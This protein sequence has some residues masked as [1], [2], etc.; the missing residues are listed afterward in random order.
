MVEQDMGKWL[1]ATALVGVV[2]AGWLWQRRRQ[3]LSG[4]VVL[5][6]G[7]SRGLG[8][9][10]AQEFARQGCRLAI[11][12]R[13]EAELERARYRLSLAGAEVI[14][15]LCDIGDQR[16]VERWV[17]LSL[18]RFGQIDILVNNA[19]IIQVGPLETMTRQD[20][21]KALDVMFWGG[22]H[23]TLAVLPPMQQQGAGQIVNITSIGGKVSVP[24]LLPYNCAKAAF[25]SLSEGLRAELQPHGI[26]VLT[27]VPGL[28]RTGSHLNAF[29]NGQQANEFTWFSLGASLPL[30]SM[31]AERAA[32][33]IVAATKKRETE[34][35]LTIPANL[36]A[37]FHGVFPGLTTEIIS[38][39]AR[40]LL[41]SADGAGRETTPGMKIRQE[42]S[43]SRQRVLDSLTTL[44]NQA[45]A[46]YNQYPGPVSVL[47]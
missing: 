19:G 9:L 17:R 38:L 22:L 37:R 44:G 3:D 33:Q 34:V 45:A 13:D 47:E 32:K 43:S 21:A 12:A 35:I 27:V 40:L 4:K 10:L 1:L 36:L 42:L 16:Q 39:V 20:F 30:L 6:T 46:R 28:M 11:C 41:P 25:I 31:N 29:F 15:T 7:G 26:S 2:G 18:E 24:H 8:Y 5:I 23:T 14:T